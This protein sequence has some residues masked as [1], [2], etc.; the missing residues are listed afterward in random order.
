MNQ[1]ETI[2]LRGNIEKFFYAGPMFSAGRLRDPDRGS[3]SFAGNLFNLIAECGFKAN[4]EMIKSA[5]RNQHSAIAWLS[6]FALTDL[7]AAT[8]IEKLGNNAM[9]VP[10]GKPFLF[11]RGGKMAEIA[12]LDGR[13]RPSAHHHHHHRRHALPR[14]FRRGTARGAFRRSR[15]SRAA[16]TWTYVM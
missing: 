12:G 10:E 16:G 8:L 9:A 4:G 2:V 13:T 14:V 7:R 5:I 11:H 6:A 3:R 1:S 15:Q